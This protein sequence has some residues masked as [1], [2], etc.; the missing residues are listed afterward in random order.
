MDVEAAVQLLE[1]AMHMHSTVVRAGT[2]DWRWHTDAGFDAAALT[3]LKLRLHMEQ[4]MPL[5][6]CG[7]CGCRA[8]AVHATGSAGSSTMA[9]EKLPHWQLLLA[10]VSPTDDCPRGGHTFLEV[11]IG[12]ESVHRLCINPHASTWIPTPSDLV[13]AQVAVLAR[14]YGLL[15]QCPHQIVDCAMCCGRALGAAAADVGARA[16]CDKVQVSQQFSVPQVAAAALSGTTHVRVCHECLSALVA[17]RVPMGSYVRVDPGRVPIMVSPA[18]RLPDLNM[19]ETRI[20][21]RMHAIRHIAFLRPAGK[22]MPGTDKPGDPSGQDVLMRH[23]HGRHRVLKPGPATV[24]GSVA[25]PDR[26]HPKHFPGEM[27]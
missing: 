14:T 5:H 8:P 10:D 11:V 13:P 12:K 26:G 16:A 21:A 2:C 17:Q 6:L 1:E 22:N 27:M 9:V 3:A 24:A 7:V 15:S 19:L 23:L 18:L 25:L 4:H 20:L